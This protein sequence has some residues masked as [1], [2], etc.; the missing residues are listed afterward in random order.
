MNILCIDTA[1]QTAN[2]ILI[3]SSKN[4]C[5]K[6]EGKH[7]ETTL[8]EIEN[9]M[10]ECDISPKDVDV[11]CVNVGPGSFTGIRVAI[12][13]TKGFSVV[14]KKL[15]F[16][17]V[18]SMELIAKEYNCCKNFSTVLNALGGR[19]F[20][21]EFQD[22]K[23]FKE[24]YLATEL[25][26]GDT[27]GVVDENLDN[28]THKVEISCNSF[29]NL[30]EDKI[31][32]EEFCSSSDLVPMYIR[33]SQAEENLQGVKIEKMSQKFI[34]D[35]YE[36]SKQA[37]GSSSWS[38]K[39]FEDELIRPDRFSYCVTDNGNVVSFINVLVCE[40]EQGKEFNILNIA[41]KEKNKGY[42]T[43]LIE[44]VKDKAKSQNI[45]NVWLEVDDKNIPALNLY[46]KL[47]FKKIAVRKKYYQNGDD[48][49]ILRCEI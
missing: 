19:Y 11:I 16:I 18:N 37:F 24:P 35:V 32:R 29:F 40:G 38:L 45:K 7:S 5:K 43:Q 28:V 39:M 8:L 9:M 13:L 20:V 2:L 36:I 30:C 3:T 15:K 49:L 27:V 1:F 33:K 10:I 47:G 26:D 41:S 17:K 44:L 42:A 46:N 14:N 21:A 25:P 22:G 34:D 23:V 12:A 31:K 6:V 4:I 48:A